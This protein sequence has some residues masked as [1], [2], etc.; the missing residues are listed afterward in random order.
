MNIKLTEEAVYQA[1]HFTTEAKNTLANNYTYMR[2]T[3]T[4]LLQEWNDKNVTQFME[5]LDHFDSYVKATAGN[6]DR[7]NEMLRHYL[8][9]MED[10]NR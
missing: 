10:Y 4:P 6:L 8:V 5:I 2:S 1:I 7:I 3:V 9:I